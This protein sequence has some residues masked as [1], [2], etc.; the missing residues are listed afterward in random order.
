MFASND[1]LNLSTD[2]RV[3]TKIQKTLEEY[4]V[5]AGSSRIGTGYSYLHKELEEQLANSFEK[6]AAIVFPTGYDAIASPAMTLLTSNDRIVIDSSS[7]ACIIDSSVASGAVLR[8]FSHN[9]PDRL[10][11]ILSKSQGK[12]ERRGHFGHH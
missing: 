3:H 6:E 2:K 11:E 10:E 8:Y 7:H 4:G 5:G 12:N 9:S 1:Y